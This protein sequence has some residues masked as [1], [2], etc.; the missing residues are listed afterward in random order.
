MRSR[1]WS[2]QRWATGSPARGTTAS[3]ISIGPSLRSETGMTSSPRCLSAALSLV[4]MRPLA[5]VIVTRMS[6]VRRSEPDGAKLGGLAAGV[7]DLVAAHVGRALALGLL[8]DG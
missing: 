3:P 1:T 2:G 8:R 6:Q 7:A 4:P 5:P